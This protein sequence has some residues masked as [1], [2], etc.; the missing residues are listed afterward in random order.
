MKTFYT[1]VILFLFTAARSQPVINANWVPSPGDNFVMQQASYDSLPF[2]ISGNNGYGLTGG[3]VTWDFSRLLPLY[4]YDTIKYFGTADTLIRQDISGFNRVYWNGDTLMIGVLAFATCSGYNS[5]YEQ[6]TN[7]DF[8]GSNIFYHFPLNDSIVSSQ[9]YS[10]NNPGTG[11]CG[12]SENY[13]GWGHLLLPG[14]LEYD[15]ALMLLQTF[16]TV[17]SVKD[18]NTDD[19]SYGF[20]IF[21]HESRTFSY[22]WI[23]S[24]IKTPVL[25]INVSQIDYAD[26]SPANPTMVT[27]SYSTSSTSV[28]FYQHYFFNGINEINSAHLKV[29]PDPATSAFT[30]SIL[31]E[32]ESEYIL[33][34]HDLSGRV[35]MQRSFTGQETIVQRDGLDAGS[36]F[37]QVMDRRTGDRFQKR[38]VFE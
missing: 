7:E 31:N 20:P 14:G 12:L 5:Y 16:D 25:F 6:T 38:V 2:N 24:G 19:A 3:D 32:P 23:V 22:Q 28:C 30:I 33:T 26:F 13:L 36:Y 17:C 37:I 34:L 18:D 9:I 35:V 8:K 1:L 29:Y 4:L 15:S 10:L 27:N 21:D 11:Y